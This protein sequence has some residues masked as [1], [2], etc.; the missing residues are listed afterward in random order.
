ML[1]AHYAY[2]VF[3]VCDSVEHGCLAFAA[4]KAVVD[5]GLSHAARL[6]ECAHLVVSKVAGVVAEGAGAAVAAHNGLRADV[7]S[8]VKALLAGVA[9]VN[10]YAAPVHFP[11][12]FSPETAHS[13]MRVAA[14]CT[15]ANVVVAVVTQRYIDHAP[16][17]EVLYVGEITVEC[18]AVFDAKHYGFAPVTL[19]FVQ[20]GGRSGYADVVLVLVNN[21]LYLVENEF[22]VLG[23]AGYGE[24]NL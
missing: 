21:I 19:V 24:V 5:G 11:Y 2:G 22:C 20:V 4:Q 17:H 3:K 1:D 12:H 7:Q 8:V 16:L 14:L 18:K 23:R 9:E 13:V 10:H 6:C 15:V